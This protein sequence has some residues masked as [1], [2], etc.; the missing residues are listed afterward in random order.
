MTTLE[1]REQIED[2][3]DQIPP[4][5]LG[6]V[7]DFVAYLADRKSED[8][9]EELLK[10]PRFMESLEKAEAEISTGSYTNWR[11][12]PFPVKD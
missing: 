2:Y 11:D 9:T 12:T 5:H 4:Y 1:I 6:S 7:L 10:I 8:A 3:I